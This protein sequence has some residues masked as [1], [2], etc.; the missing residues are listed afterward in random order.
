M[1]SPVPRVATSVAYVDGV[2]GG[3]VFVMTLDGA[4]SLAA[5]M[6]G[7]DEPEDPDAA[8]SSPSSSSP[9]CPRP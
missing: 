8:P 7:M 5:A 1:E 4:R 3:N 2:T 6:M 9:P